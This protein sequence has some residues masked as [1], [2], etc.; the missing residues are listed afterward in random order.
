MIPIR[1]L[2]GYF[3][4]FASFQVAFATLHNV[5]VD[6]AILTGDVVP[7]Y[8]PSASL[9]DQGSNC[10]T[11]LVQ[12]DPSQA[13]NGTWH[14]ATFQPRTKVSQT[15]EFTFRGSALYIFFILANTVPQAETLT[16]MIFYLDEIAVGTF[17]HAPSSSTDYQ[18]NVPVYV[19][20]S[21]VSGEHTMMIEPVNSGNPVLMLFD[22]LVYTTD[23]DNATTTNSAPTPSGIQNTAAIIGGTVGGVSA[24]VLVTASLLCYRRYKRR[25]GRL[26]WSG[27]G[28]VLG[29]LISLR[30]PF[31]GTPS[32]IYQISP[33]PEPQ[34]RNGMQ[35]SPVILRPSSIPISIDPPSTASL[36]SNNA[37]LLAQVEL[38]RDEVY[39]LRHLQDHNQNPVNLRLQEPPEYTQGP[40]ALDFVDAVKR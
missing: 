24:L 28:P 21:L 5:T 26:P 8:L 18:Y 19:N 11:Y 39:H 25:K 23:A 27:E 15:I 29:S 17:V 13:Y 22:Y 35:T 40:G 38:L 9:W 34:L 33:L 2:L 36:S 14:Y 32:G 30:E 4:L 12:P 31:E 6:D 20:E 37:G 1:L 10:S 16:D 3:L 7:Q